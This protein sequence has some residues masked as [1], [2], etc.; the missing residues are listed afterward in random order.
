MGKSTFIALLCLSLTAFAQDVRPVAFVDLKAYSGDWHE[1]Q[2][3][4][5]RFQYDKE[6]SGFG[7]CENTVAQYTPRDDGK[8]TVINS[9]LRTNEKGETLVSKA[10]ALATVQESSRGARLKVNFTGMAILRW[11]GVGNGD[12]WVLGLGPLTTDGRYCWALVGEPTR[13]YGWIL[14]RENHLSASTLHTIFELA[15]SNGYARSQFSAARL[16]K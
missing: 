5:N 6:T 3:I 15:E 7:R 13:N 4:P 14:A 2:R 9:C 11:L 1:I 16:A 8:I 12:Y 10:E